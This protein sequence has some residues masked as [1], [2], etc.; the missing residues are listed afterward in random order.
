MNNSNFTIISF[1]QFIH[2]RNLKTLSDLGVVIAPPV[3]AFYARPT[4]LNEM[5]DHTV[6][7][8][9]DLFNIESGKVT[10]WGENVGKRSGSRQRNE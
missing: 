7:R 4:N 10:R 8:V 6:G 1:Y 3:P 9:L 2:L 5:I